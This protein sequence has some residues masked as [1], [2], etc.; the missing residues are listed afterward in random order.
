MCYSYG[1]YGGKPCLILKLNN[2]YGWEPEP[3]YN[4]SQVFIKTALFVG[5]EKS[6]NARTPDNIYNVLQVTILVQ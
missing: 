5:A 4:L 1:M 3:Y 6:K 2:V